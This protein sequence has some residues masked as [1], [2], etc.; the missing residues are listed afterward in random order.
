[1]LPRTLTFLIACAGIYGCRGPTP[2]LPKG[3]A[4]PAA[5]PSAAAP[6]SPPPAALAGASAAVR[7]A[8]EHLRTANTF[9]DA[10]VG[11]SGELSTYVAAFRTILDDTRAAAIFEAL[12]ASAS[13]TREGELY[14]VAGLY[15]TDPSA[16]ALAIT[17]LERS[18]EVVQ[19]RHGCSGEREPVASVIRSPSSSRIQVQA[20]ET[21]TQWFTTHR[22][23]EADIA[24]GYVPLSFL[25]VERPAPHGPL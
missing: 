9:D 7:A 12:Y 21:L 6:S 11:F 20:G 17:A 16:F 5:A 13:A 4:P 24:G 19:T 14:G 3:A 1:M 18:T 2:S 8:F 25:A 22:T 23:G 10:H 15:F